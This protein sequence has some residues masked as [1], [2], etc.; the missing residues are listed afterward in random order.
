MSDYDFI[1]DVVNEI[2]TN[3]KKDKPQ[4]RKQRKVVPVEER[5]TKVLNN[6]K[7]CSFKQSSKSKYCSRHGNARL[8][9]DYKDTKNQT[10]LTEI[11]NQTTM[12][13]YY[14]KI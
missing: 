2:M 14:K 8:K 1:D 5:C 10:E 9:D 7:L 6:T 3:V 4:K 12:N 11:K 13:D